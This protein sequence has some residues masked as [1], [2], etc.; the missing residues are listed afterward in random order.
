LITLRGLNALKCCDTVIYDALIDTELLDFAPVNAERICVGKRAGAHSASQEEINALLAEKALGGHTVARLKGGDPF[1]FGRG[2]EERNEL[3]KHGIP[4]SIIPGISS[5][6]AV[7]E[8][9]GIPVTHRKV[10]RV[11]HVI[12]AHTAGYD[13]LLS[14]YS[15]L[16]GTLVFLMGL[17]RLPELTEALMNGGKSADT[18]AAVISEGGTATQRCV[19]GTLADIAEKAAELSA[20][21]VMVVGDTASFDLSPGP[22][23][24]VT[25]TGTSLLTEKLDRLLEAQKMEVTRINHV[26]IKRG[27][28]IPA[29][30]GYGC[31]AFTSSYG[32]GIFGE[33]CRETHTDLRSLAGIRFAAVGSGTAQAL[34][35]LGIN[36]DIVPGSFTAAALGEAVAA[37]PDIGKVLILRASR[38][39]EELPETLAGHGISFDDIH[40]Y[41]TVYNGCPPRDVKSGFVVFGSS[42]GVK[43]FFDNGFTVAEGTKLVCIGA[44]TAETAGKYTSCRIIRAVPDTA[45]G[46]ANA[47]KGEMKG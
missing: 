33:Y 5:C 1:V 12:T 36:A 2:G 20:P 19:R 42:F 7:P 17:G 21:A 34:A 4:Y 45:E 18:P 9:A 23:P 22:M 47:I 32:V 39:S 10:S 13:A 14:G 26:G 40:I 46:A 44:K 16:D 27:A 37:V 43:A 28:G 31:I 15:A 25:V 8:L 29:P 41:D 24:S 6:I 30:V 11:F 38:G 3:K 35:Q